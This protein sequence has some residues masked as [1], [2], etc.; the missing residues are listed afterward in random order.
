MPLDSRRGLSPIHL[1]RTK[2]ATKKPCTCAKLSTLCFYHYNGQHPSHRRVTQTA[3]TDPK[4]RRRKALLGWGVTS[5]GRW[6]IQGPDLRGQ[7][8]ASRY[9]LER[10]VGLG[11]TASVYAAVD[12]HL[13]RRVAVKVLHPEHARSDEQRR[14]IRQEAQLAACVE[15][16]NVATLLD[17]GAEER[18]G[19][20]RLFFLIMPLLEG[21]TLRELV[22]SGPIPWTRAVTLVRQLLAGVAAIHH[23][24]ALHRDLKS[25][26]CLVG[27]GESGKH[28]WILDFGLAKAVVSGLLSRTHR[29]SEGSIVGTLPYLSPEQARGLPLD[30][31]SD[32]YAVGVILFELLTRH[33][34]FLGSDYDVLTAIVNEPPPS[35]CELAPQ[36]GIPA[37]L[38]A[39]VMRALAKEPTMRFE[40]A[41]DF[42]AALAAVLIGEVEAESASVQLCSPSHAGCAEAEASLAAWSSFE[43]KRA[44]R[45]AK[46]AMRINR[47]WSPLALLMSLVPEED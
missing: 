21:R 45:M 16:M 18:P 33:L 36:A 37:A 28:L 30:V 8:L 42:S 39:V 13:R 1:V 46:L 26:N 29:S 3:T 7:V 9:L 14:R 5:P 15:H 2:L 20:E 6:S 38:E 43:Y 25:G 12:K 17:L 35:P 31:R 27:P 44:H 23:A 10:V 19:G 40:S 34:P 24:G 11:G 4:E 32:L 47:A 22:L 41:T